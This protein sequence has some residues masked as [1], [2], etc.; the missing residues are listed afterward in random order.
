MSKAW[1]NNDTQN[2]RDEQYTATYPILSLKSLSL[3]RFTVLP[4]YKYITT[5]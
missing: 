3:A 2:S 1:L 4:L 5:C